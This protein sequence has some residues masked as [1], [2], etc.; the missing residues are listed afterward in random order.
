MKNIN[1]GIVNL[2]ISNKLKDSYFS[3]SLIEE[4]K[5]TLFEFFNV[6]ENSPILQLEF[7]VFNNLESKHIDSDDN[8]AIKYIDNNIKLFEVYTLNEIESEQ[9]KLSPFLVENLTSLDVEKI[10]LYNSIDCLI[11]ESLKTA[12]E[13]DVDSIHESFSIV[14]NH[15]KRPKKTIIESVEEINDDVIEIAV[16]KFNEKYESLNEDD[17]SL[18]YKLIHYNDNEKKELLEEYKQNNLTILENINRD[19]IKDN[20]LKAIQKIREM[21]YK[22]NSV[23]DDIISLHELKKELL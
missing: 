11:K 7:K 3:N 23:D 6:V 18:L 22:H 13:V 21:S 16:N 1:I 20:I 15:I 14:L 4:S 12:D 17:K 8:L 9:N 2:I 5:Q 19:T 10:S